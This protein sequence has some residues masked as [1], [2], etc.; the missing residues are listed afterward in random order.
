MAKGK[1]SIFV[2]TAATRP[3]S[4]GG[5]FRSTEGGAFELLD[6]GILTTT[7]VQAITVHPGDANLIFVGT[8]NG[9]F[10]SR[11]GGDRWELLPVPLDRQQ[12]WSV[13]IHPT[14]PN[15]VIAGTAPIGFFRSDDLGDSW[16]ALKS[17]PEGERFTLSFKNSRVMRVT[18][19][20]NDTN[21]WYGA[22]EINGVVASVDGGET[23]RDVSADLIRLSEGLKS[24]IET[25]DD[26]EG[27]LD[28]HAVAVSPALPGTVFYACRMGVFSSSDGGQTWKDHK[29]SRFSPLSYSRDMR[30]SNQDP[31][32]IYT[33]LSV[34][35][36]SDAGSM[37]RSDD[38]G[39]NWKRIDP[40]ISPPSTI[41]GLG[42]HNTDPLKVFSATRAGQVYS[43]ADGGESW[44][45]QQLPAEAGDAFCVGGS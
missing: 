25:E 14:L 10:R 39:V 21:K 34:S 16:R 9:V 33:A 7:G 23:W 27:M 19:D 1:S 32:V 30:V 3:D 8:R 28:G 18:I 22:T 11:D 43:T 41:M 2:G 31:N 26:A 29:I 37:W 20:P 15:T 12:I 17:P 40:S 5:L 45:T 6:N 35:S 44:R 36:R 24:R 42:I 13:I 38:L 4:I